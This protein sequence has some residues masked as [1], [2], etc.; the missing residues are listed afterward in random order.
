MMSVN[1][2][3][4]K[5]IKS[6]SSF[7]SYTVG[8]GQ[9]G[10]IYTW[11]NTKLPLTIHNV[12][13][14]E[15]PDEIS[16]NNVKFVA[17]G[18]DHAI[19]ITDAGKVVGW[20]E[21]DN[22]QYGDQGSLYGMKSQVIDMPLELQNG[23]INAD[24][25]KQVACGY[26]VSAIVMNSG[27]VY[28]W[29]NKSSGAMNLNSIRLKTDVEKIVFFGTQCAALSKTGQLY[30]E[31][32]KDQYGNIEKVE[33]NG[34]RHFINII[35]DDYFAGRKV[36]DI[37][38]SNDSLAILAD[39]GELLI[40]GK[41]FD[42]TNKNVVGMPTLSDGE[43]YISVQGGTRHFVAVTNKRNIYAFGENHLKQCKF[44]G[45]LE[46]DEEIFVGSFQNYIVNKETHKLEDSWGFKG[47]F[48]GS[49]DQGRD[50]FARI[51]NGGKMS[52][53]I[54]AVAVI[55]SAV[56]GI[57]VG[58][59]SG[60][61]GGWVDILLMRISEVFSAIPFLP[62]ALILSAVMAGSN[63]T[64]DTRIFIIM[65]ILGLLSWTGLAHMVRGQILAEREKEFVLAAKS[66]GVKE[67]RIA[68]KHIL[69]NVMSI[70][71]VSLTLDFAGCLL[72]ESSLSYLGFGVKLPRPTWGN[73]LD[74]CNNA[75]VIGTYWWRWVFPSLFLLISTIS[76]NII[77]D[78]LRDVLDPKS[79][80]ER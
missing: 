21:F 47:F 48:M 71:L 55:I 5:Q 75:V 4:K 63:V 22:A 58:V 39:D 25:V 46:E 76:I 19:A 42:T 49:D 8:L 7:S 65:C 37:A 11:G 64:E 33:A 79:S 15:L 57:V 45:Q 41:Q 60:Y 14:A 20:G 70:I 74:G 80:A 72:T 62:F 50:V 54:G 32:A 69:P 77:G 30:L 10:K 9:D 17:A 59:I 13:M 27:R 53:T 3:V 66:M 26:Q 44:K 36:I 35:D 12:D 18:F 6:I 43:K 23:T 68:F 40:T 1:R 61:F 38:A 2:G 67:R 56:I 16:G 24:E 29:G 52:L 28:A 31:S 51:V 34:D 78:T 73:M